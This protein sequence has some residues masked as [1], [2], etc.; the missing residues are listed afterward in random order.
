MARL[1]FFVGLLPLL[2]GSSAGGF[3]VGVAVVCV[4]AWLVTGD[5]RWL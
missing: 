5:Y 2:V 4:V 1:L 3:L